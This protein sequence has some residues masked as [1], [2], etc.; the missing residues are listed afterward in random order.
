MTADPYM[1]SGG[2]NDPG[3]WN[4]YAYAEGDPANNTDP[5]GL[6][7]ATDA[8]GEY[9]GSCYELAQQ[10][11]ATFYPQQF[12]ALCG[13]PSWWGGVP[14]GGCYALALF[15][16]GVYDCGGG[17]GGGGQTTAPPPPSCQISLATSGPA[18]WPASGQDPSTVY[19]GPSSN[20]LAARG[21]TSPDV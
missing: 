20:T 12:M 9:G 1:A 19:Y 4:R 13:D 3:S 10:G 8:F 5:H 7:I 2:P 15:G 11:F 17:G 6:Y 14:Y 18:S 21:K 16:E